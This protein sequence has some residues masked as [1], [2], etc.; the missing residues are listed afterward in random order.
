MFPPARSRNETGF[1]QKILEGLTNKYIRNAS[2][3]LFPKACRVLPYLA[4]RKSIA[5]IGDTQHENITNLN[6]DIQVVV[7]Q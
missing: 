5:E 1:K 3:L 7:F 2:A 4:S 6:H